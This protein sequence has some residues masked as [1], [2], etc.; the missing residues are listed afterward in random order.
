MALTVEQIIQETRQWSP[1]QLDELLK[2]LTVQS[3]SAKPLSSDGSDSAVSRVREFSKK[4][5]ALWEGTGIEVSTEEIVNALRE[6]SS[7]RE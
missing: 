7:R 6:S 1:T 3:A 2:A 5:D 4:I